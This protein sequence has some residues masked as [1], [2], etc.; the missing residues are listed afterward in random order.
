VASRLCL[1]CS[2]TFGR[3]VQM[4]KCSNCGAEVAEGANFCATCGRSLRPLAIARMME[5]ARRALDSN[6]ND[7][8]A[9]Y[10][11][12]LAYRLSGLEGLALQEFE[13]VAEAQPDFADVHYELAQLYLKA[14]RKEEAAAALQR[15]LELEPEHQGARRLLGKVT[16]G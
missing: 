15:V 1:N 8:S 7:L 11:L 16:A 6:P 4:Q 13:R 9:R 14:N 12:A 2:I 5:D 3:G 10:N